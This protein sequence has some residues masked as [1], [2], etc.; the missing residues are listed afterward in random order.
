MAAVA[1]AALAIALPTGTHAATAHSFIGHGRA[2]AQVPGVN[3]TCGAPMMHP[4]KGCVYLAECAECSASKCVA[5]YDVYALDAMAESMLRTHDNDADLC[6]MI[7][8]T[9]AG[10]T[11]ADAGSME[12]EITTCPDDATIDAAADT[13]W[14]TL[15]ATSVVLGTT[16]DSAAVTKTFLADKCVTS[17]SMGMCASKLD[18]DFMA[19]SEH[20]DCA[21]I[22]GDYP[23]PICRTD[24]W[25]VNETCVVGPIEALGIEGSI[26]KALR[27]TALELH[28]ECQK[29]ETEVACHAFDGSAMLKMLNETNTA[30]AAGT[31]LA[32]SQE[33]T[34]GYAMVT[35]MGL[36]SMLFF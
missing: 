3:D 13:I 1:I 18:V 34:T 16:L 26:A 8:T 36:L 22:N 23:P 17:A 27:K 2:L 6:A 25:M 15:A 19:L 10:S 21:V 31:I 12:R 35:F 28:A 32:S 24:D 29:L 33:K 5:H 4:G 20:P 14:T 11:A 9:L 30:A 7:A